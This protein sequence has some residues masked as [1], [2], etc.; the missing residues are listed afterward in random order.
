MAT[1][2]RP[3]FG[4]DE[5]FLQV[6]TSKRSHLQVFCW[7]QMA[8]KPASCLRPKYSGDATGNSLAF[9]S[10]FTKFMARGLSL[11]A[12]DN[13][14]GKHMFQHLTSYWK[15]FP[16]RCQSSLPVWSI[17]GLDRPTGGLSQSG[18]SLSYLVISCHLH[19]S[20]F[21]KCRCHREHRTHVTAVTAEIPRRLLLPRPP[22]EVAG[23]DDLH[24]SETS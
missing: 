22:G 10:S 23:K 5:L 12:L 4:S 17:H 21:A 9:I 15:N 19:P 14:P 11:E 24:P 20:T 1:A 6:C 8:P 3:V 2:Q 13:Q 7:A 18:C 16:H